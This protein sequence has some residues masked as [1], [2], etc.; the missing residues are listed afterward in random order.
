MQ[1]GGFN[2][3]DLINPAEAMYKI[4][5]QVQELS[6]KVSLDKNYK[7]INTADVERKVMPDFKKTL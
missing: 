4:D 3:L 5:N 1:S 2:I 6:N 7:I